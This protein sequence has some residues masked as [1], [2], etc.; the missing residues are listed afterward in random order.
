MCVSVCVCVRMY[1]SVCLCVCLC[2]CVRKYV[3]VCL[4]VCATSVTASINRSPTTTTIHL[5]TPD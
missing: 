5:P 3:S 1:V 4:C 2:V